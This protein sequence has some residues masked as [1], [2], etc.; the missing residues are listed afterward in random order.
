MVNRTLPKGRVGDFNFLVGDWIV[1]D[2]RLASR[3]TGSD[4]RAP[5]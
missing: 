4:A 1:S 3:W 5:A 2:R